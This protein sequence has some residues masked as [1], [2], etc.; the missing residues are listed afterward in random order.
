[1]LQLPLIWK[2]IVELIYFPISHFK[3][4]HSPVAFCF[5]YFLLVV[6]SN[7]VNAQDSSFLFESRIKSTFLDKSDSVVRVKATRVAIMGEK[8]KRLL[9]M[10]S[11]F[12]ISK[13]GHL[14]TTGLL[15]DAD[16]IWIEYKQSYL[17]AEEIGH[18]SMC[19]LSLLKLLEAPK[20]L[21]YVRISDSPKDLEIG[22]FLIGITCA[23][24]F[25]IGPTWGL[26]QSYE[27]SFGKRLFPTKMLRS[28]L[29]L[30]P[31]EVGAPVFDLNGR[32]VG[33]THAALPDLKSSFLLPAKACKRIRDDL[34]LSGGVEYGWFGITTTRK[35]NDTNS[36][37]VVI[38]G[39]I[40]DSPAQKSNLKVGDVL[41]N[42]G[43]Y[44][45]YSQGDLANASFFSE[46]GTILDFKVKRNGKEL[47]IPLSVK[48][49]PTQ[50]IDSERNITAISDG[51]STTQ[52]NKD[53]VTEEN[54]S[55]E[56]F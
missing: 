36:F 13:E 9:K 2:K 44:E 12:F 5:G 14:L 35:I 27:Y 40:D 38:N 50:T 22:S 8:T 32:F 47:S 30:G 25:E 31:G 28:S 51:N 4:V 20:D 41:L 18:D 48:S 39:F 34:L 23:L 56:Q 37:E 15:P 46:P 16:R 54:N 53:L 6:F 3:T 17:L 1:M 52:I 11:G 29:A 10:G 7:L 21:S 43:N 33:I 45:I 42:V 26:L 19:N 49:R 24:E 55:S